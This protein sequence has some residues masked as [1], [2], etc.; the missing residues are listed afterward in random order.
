M[1]AITVVDR[2]AGLDGLTLTDRPH[3]TRPGSPPGEPAWPGT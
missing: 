1:Q 3:R 2:A